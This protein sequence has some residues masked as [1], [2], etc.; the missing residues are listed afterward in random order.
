M[1][2]RIILFICS[3]LVCGFA[4]RSQ[5]VSRV[6]IKGKSAYPNTLVRLI[7]PEDLM[8]MHES[9]LAY[10]MSDSEGNFSLTA[11]VSEIK[12][13]KI[14][15]GLERGE[16]YL[17][18]SKKYELSVPYQ[19]SIEPISFFEKEP[20]Y[21]DL[22]SADDR[23]FINQI[24]E[25]NVVYNTFLLQ[26]FN[27]LYRGTRHDLIDSL[28][29]EINR[30]VPKAA[31][32]Y[33]NDYVTYKIAALE[34]ASRYRSQQFVLEN[35]FLNKPVLYSNIEYMSLFK[36]IYSNYISRIRSVSPL[37]LYQILNRGYESLDSLLKTDS[38]LSQDKRLR[39]LVMLLNLMELY[40]SQLYETVLIENQL[41]HI[42]QN[43]SYAE[44]RKIAA[45]I[46]KQKQTLAYGTSAP[47]FRL[48]AAFQQTFDLRDYADKAVLIS[49]IKGNCLVCENALLDLESLWQR[50][51]DRYY[52]VTI[53]TIDAFEESSQFFQ[54]NGLSW[55]LLNLSQHILLLEQYQVRT[56]PEFI[57]LLPGNRIGMAPAPGPERYLEYHLNRIS[58]Q[59]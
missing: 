56:F 54:D 39:E 14:A 11:H 26:Y 25:I 7:V 48:S 4:L 35:L 6:S 28:R 19:E 31:H 20:L 40:G 23:G 17:V 53:A 3:L 33:I 46:I 44:H 36:E 10:A 52:F 42:K 24:H 34:L 38:G 30:R 2:K 58:S 41:N 51:Q 22:V 1:P 13:A 9:T 50:F 55:P 21:F 59:N 45:N 32:T 43:S 18:P 29:F 27:A 8:S 47:Q 15:F 5:N 37:D 12:L 49:F 57:I 16:I